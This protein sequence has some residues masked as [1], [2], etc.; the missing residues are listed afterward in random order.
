MALATQQI[1]TGPLVATPKGFQFSPEG[2][3]AW[4]DTEW[5]EYYQPNMSLW[6]LKKEK[7][8]KT[9]Y[10]RDVKAAGDETSSKLA[11]MSLW[12]TLPSSL[13]A[14]VDVSHTK[15][16]ENSPKWTPSFK[17]GQIIER[18][19]GS[20][21][22][23]IADEIVVNYVQ[24]KLPLVDNRDFLYFTFVRKFQAPNPK[25]PQDPTPTRG[26]M[27]A[28]VSTTNASFP[29]PKGYTRGEILKGFVVI[30]EVPQNPNLCSYYWQQ[31]LDLHGSIPKKLISEQEIDSML[32]QHGSLVKILTG[33]L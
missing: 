2:T 16:I 12:A 19:P 22:G 20:Q 10:K 3:K 26:I 23:S 29:P 31:Q 18:L 11:P 33:Q 17:G 4:M 8:G 21:F 30:H 27:F 7:D 1:V 25:F 24:H 5:R 6:K 9:V 32:K 13:D 28:N 15:F 14:A